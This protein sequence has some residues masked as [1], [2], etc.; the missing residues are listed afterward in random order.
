LKKGGIRGIDLDAMEK[1]SSQITLNNLS[2][3]LS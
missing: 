3:T 2:L 1:D